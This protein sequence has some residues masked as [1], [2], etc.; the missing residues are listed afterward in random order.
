MMV[1]QEVGSE[2]QSLRARV[3]DLA[4][5]QKGQSDYLTGDT[6]IPAIFQQ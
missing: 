3:L 5:D 4:N 1:I 6:G 2:K